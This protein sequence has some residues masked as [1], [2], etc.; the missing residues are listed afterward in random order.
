MMK[1]LIVANWKMNPPTLA[2]AKRLFGSVKKN[3]G[4]NKKAE[5]VICPPFPYIAQFSTAGGKLYLG[6]QNCSWED[7]GSFTG[8]VAP[9]TLKDMGCKYVILGHSERRRWFKEGDEMINKKIKKALSQKLKPILCIGETGE[10]REKGKTPLVLRAQLEKGL[11]QKPKLKNDLF[12]DE[13]DLKTKIN[14]RE[15]KNII[16]AYEPIWAIGAGKACEINEVM[17]MGLLIRKIIG[18]LYNRQTAK[19]IRILYGGSA[20]SKNARVLIYDTGM[21]GLLIGGAALNPKEF[22]KVIKEVN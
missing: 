2:E 21:N 5:I 18:E 9:V 15:I 20:D 3:I 1:Y 11:G 17:S 22:A 7:K 19:K 16:I 12:S 10:E 14:N 4:K 8:E 6:G 13:K